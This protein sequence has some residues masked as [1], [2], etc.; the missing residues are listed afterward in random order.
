MHSPLWRPIVSPAPLGASPFVSY[1]WIVCNTHTHSW[2]ETRT[3]HASDCST[4]LLYLFHHAQESSLS[5]IIEDITIPAF[6]RR[7]VRLE[8][9]MGRN[10]GG[11]DGPVTMLLIEA[12]PGPDCAD[13]VKDG[14]RALSY[15]VERS[16]Y[17]TQ[18]IISDDQPRRSW[19]RRRICLSASPRVESYRRSW[20][21]FNSNTKTGLSAS[22]TSYKRMNSVASREFGM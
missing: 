8:L 18:K 6:L 19:R 4:S 2:Y 5:F 3:Q 16:Q 11:L 15:I 10:K 21:G 12:E 1:I 13:S 7:S 17:Y 22:K 20:G 9:G 14:K